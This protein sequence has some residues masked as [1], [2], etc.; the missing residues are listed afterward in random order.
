M[1]T[2]TWLWQRTM[3]ER[4]RWIGLMEFR[5]IERHA[6]MY[7]KYRTRITGRD[8]DTLKVPTSGQT[9][10]IAKWTP[11]GGL[12]SRMLIDLGAD[13][14]A[15]DSRLVRDRSQRNRDVV[16]PGS[17]NFHKSFAIV[18]LGFA[19]L[20]PALFPHTAASATGAA[21]LPITR[22]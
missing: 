3:L 14:P 13:R 1:A 18:S 10:F 9:P 22:A 19:L 4:E 21:T 16:T 5:L 15:R 17:K 6:T 7:K 20:G 12:F 11:A 2:S 8:R